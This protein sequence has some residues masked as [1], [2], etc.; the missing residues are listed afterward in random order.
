MRALCGSD[1]AV[2]SGREGRANPPP[3]VFSVPL[4]LLKESLNRVKANRSNANMQGFTDGF[5]YVS[6]IRN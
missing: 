5:Y 2:G 1:E 3:R 4:S 6:A